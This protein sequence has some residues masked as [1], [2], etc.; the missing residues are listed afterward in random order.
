MDGLLGMLPSF[1]MDSVVLHPASLTSE[2]RAKEQNP[3]EIAPG[4]DFPAI[5]AKIMAYWGLLGLKEWTNPG[6]DY[7]LMG[8][9]TGLINPRIEQVRRYLFRVQAPIFT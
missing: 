2:L 4:V 3:S 1:E 5:E 6:A 8:M 7:K 9:W